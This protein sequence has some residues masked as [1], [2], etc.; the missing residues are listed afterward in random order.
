[1]TALKLGIT[2]NVATESGLEQALFGSGYSQ[3]VKF[4]YDLLHNIGHEPYLL[5]TNEIENQILKF[6][7]NSQYRA[8]TLQ[9]VCDNHLSLDIV[10]EAGVTISKH[11]RDILKKS[12]GTR[13]VSVRYGHSMIM[14]MERI[15]LQDRT[16]AGIHV[17][18]P[19]FL[20][21]LPHF[22]DSVQYLATLY[23]C[24]VRICPYIWEPDFVNERFTK[25]QYNHLPDIYVMEP[26]IN[27]M[28][29][30]LIPLAIIEQIYRQAPDAFGKATILNSTHF[31]KQ[32]YF[33]ENIVRNMSSAID[34]ANKVYFTQRQKFDSVFK[35]PDILLGHQWNCELNNLYLEALYKGVPLVH[36]SPPLKEVGFYYPAFETITGA[37]ACMKAIQSFTNAAESRDKNDAFL[38]RFSVTNKNVKNQYEKLIEEV[39][40]T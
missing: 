38:T 11:N 19:D 30:A 12:F 24:P 40:N 23:D 35:R 16:E 3:T 32:T 15:F 13:V 1:M 14:D 37:E 39:M 31:Q 17:S 29:N 9:Q 25:S 4:F 34:K 33:L 10:F 21:I 5:V 7:E 8:V 2:I 28:K 22:E 36:N 27:V 26:N 6:K 18:K 20:W